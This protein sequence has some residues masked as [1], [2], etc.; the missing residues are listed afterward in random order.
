[1]VSIFWGDIG[2][3]FFFGKKES[4]WQ[5]NEFFLHLGYKLNLKIIN[6]FKIGDFV[7]IKNGSEL[8]NGYII[9]GDWAGKVVDADEYQGEEETEYLIELDAQTLDVLDDDY[10]KGIL[11]HSLVV[12]DCF[13]F[14]K[15]LELST[16]RDT[17]ESWGKAIDKVLERAE[18]FEREIE[19][20]Y[21]VQSKKFEEQKKEWPIA[22]LKSSFYEPQKGIR[23]KSVM[24]V[25]TSFMT[26]MREAT[27][28]LSADWN[29][30]TLNFA[31]LVVVPSEAVTE[32]EV[33][34]AYGDIIIQFF[35]YLDS[36]KH[37]NNAEALIETMEEIKDEI[38]IE[39]ANKDNWSND[40][41]LLMEAY[42]NGV[43]L[44]NKEEVQ[45]YFR[46][47]REA[48]AQRLAKE[49]EIMDSIKGIGRNQK[50]TI[51][52]E[53]GRLV[54]DVKFKKVMA[55]LKSGICKVLKK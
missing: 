8:E 37:I 43:D 17:D 22:F 35:K 40:K 5:F 34:E 2:R 10:L 23:E 27:V 16:R 36:E 50:I 54:E 6:V 7:K 14:G 21:I 1:M 38:P 3:L 44:S 12:G 49:K 15:Q 39:A 29:T 48:A 53:D 30:S 9:T 46:L 28:P 52:Y 11:R 31:C 32:D 41:L 47:Q 18:V 26:A 24:L 25:I 55:D 42:E 33:F 20:E 4:S 45:V 51:Q 19:E 13:A